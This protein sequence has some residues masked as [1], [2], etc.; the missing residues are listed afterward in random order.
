VDEL[1]RAGALIALDRLEAQSAELAHPDALEDRADRRQR[2]IEQLGDLGAR[3][4]QAAQ[5]RH[6]LDRPLVG[7]V[8]HALGR[9][10]AIE[11]T[12]DPLGAVAANPL[13]A[14]A[15]AHFGR[16][17]GLRDRPPVLDDPQHHPLALSE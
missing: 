4:A 3:E 5:R 15:G 10:G 9:R 6:H 12:P 11:Q 13:R 8:G 2:P 7:A 17:G 1:A 16:L 14:R